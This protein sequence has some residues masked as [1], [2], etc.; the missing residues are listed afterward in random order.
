MNL[1]IQ[2]LRESYDFI[3]Q[4][5]KL[6]NLIFTMSIRGFKQTYVRNYF[7]LIWSILDPIAFVAVLYFVFGQRFSS[8]GSN[9]VPFTV[10]LF[11]GYIAFDFFS[12]AINAI[13]TSIQNHSYLLKKVNFK[14][15]IL[16]IVALLTDL[17]MHGIVFASAIVLLLIHGI[18]PSFMWLQ[19]FY[20]LFSLCTFLV[21]V[22]WLTSSVYLFFPDLK[23]IIGIV[24]RVLFFL[25]PI[26]WKMEGLFAEHQF[27]L[28]FN[29]MYYI[30]NGYRDSLLYNRGF[31]EHP[32][33]TAY[34]WC[35][36]IVFLFSGIIVFKKLRPHF[37]DV[38]N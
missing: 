2:F 38:S 14:V 28:K 4:I 1:L 25:T 29:P 33:L 7:G 37:A 12:G 15:A 27:V 3:L 22:G 34:F 24:T 19:V 18:F 10:Y 35:V 9:V 6:K 5:F 13:T 23:N 30:V 8:H 36:T 16:P 31:W 20:Y 21:A 17:I 26:F 32:V 11:T